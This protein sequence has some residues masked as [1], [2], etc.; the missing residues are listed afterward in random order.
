VRYYQAQETFVAVVD[1]QGGERLFTKGEAVAESHP[2]VRRDVAAS[3]ADRER[4][5][6]FRLLDDGEP[7]V[8]A[9]KGDG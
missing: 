6:L 2:M 1:D 4:V 9:T 5:P 8:K 7:A 3:K